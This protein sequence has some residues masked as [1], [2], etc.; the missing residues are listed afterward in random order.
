M[1]YRIGRH[2]TFLDEMIRDLSD[3][4]LPAL[5]GFRTSVPSD[6]AM[7][8][9]DAGATLLDILTFYEERIANEGY[10]RTATERRSLLELARLVGYRPRPGLSASVHLAFTVQN[11]YRLTIPRGTKAQS[12]PGQDELPQMFETSDPIEA[13]AEWNQLSV[14][15]RRPQLGPVPDPDGGPGAA[16]LW[17]KGV[18]TGLRRNAP[19]L[20]EEPAR[21]RPRLFRV[22]EVVVDDVAKRTRVALRPWLTLGIGR[23]TQSIAASYGT[24]GAGFNT[25]VVGPKVLATLE[26]IAEVASRKTD[27]EVL[28]RLTTTTMPKLR[29]LVA[30]LT[31]T[32][33]NLRPWLTSVIAAFD[34]AIELELDAIATP[35]TRPVARTAYTFGSATRSL[36]GG[37]G[38]LMARRASAVPTLASELGSRAGGTLG[39]VTALQPALKDVLPTV[40]ANARIAPMPAL[41]AYALRVRAGVFGNNA[42]TRLDGYRENGTPIVHEWDATDMF[43]AED[44]GEVHLDAS[45]EAVSPGSWVV[46]DTADVPPVFQDDAALHAAGHAAMRVEVAHYP[47]LFARAQ[48]VRSGGSRAAYG[49][50][51]PSTSVRIAD[52]SGEPTWITFTD[53]TTAPTPE[54]I[55]SA[56]ATRPT[57]DPF[58]VIRRT[59]VLAGAEALELDDAPIDDPLCDGT[60]TAAIELGDLHAGLEPG[61]WVIVS[62]ERTDVAGTSGVI[63]S[64]LRRIADVRHDAARDDTD[65]VLPGETMH[66]YVSLDRPLDYCYRRDTVTVWGN[67]ADAT[68]G[69]TQRETLGGGDGSQPFQQFT[70]RVGPLTHVASTDADGARSTLEERVN[71]VR[72]HERRSLAGAPPDAHD[73]VTSVT[74]DARTTITHGDGVRAARL[75]TGR[76]NVRAVYRVGIGRAANVGG[77]RISILASRP[78]GLSEVINPLPSSGGADP[79][80]AEQLRRNVPLGLQALDRLVSLRDYGDFARA[81]AG[82]GKA[83]VTQ[84]SHGGRETVHVTIAGADDIPILP[85]SDLFMNL[86]ASFIRLGDIRQPVTL[87]VRELVLLVIAARIRVADDYSWELV[88]PRVRAALLARFGFDRRELGQ[89]VHSSEVIATIAAVPGVEY[90][91]LD[92]FGGIP[93]VVAG[94]TAAAPDRHAI[95]PDEIA[96][97]VAARVA[98]VLPAGDAC[99]WSPP[100][101]PVRVRLAGH[102][103]N[104]MLAPA[105]LAILS[106]AVPSTLVLREIP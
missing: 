4:E 2:A 43:A 36:A 88:E 34:D 61:R 96:A 90:V 81:F 66:T 52:L 15:R 95:T 45:Y 21:A 69:E 32:A 51:G 79:D 18:S 84:L 23:I 31:A 8:M 27:A 103:E 16:V 82:V 93:A 59:S 63:A 104:G 94:G 25:G 65:T 14:R 100:F 62:G 48:S 53:D 101:C 98:G 47:L 57:R 83:S 26:E 77:G 1:R 9:L 55:A 78:L 44:P 86:Q 105:Q 56:T 73:Y 22:E 35:A 13:R 33:K 75:P 17:L 87:G 92:T 37:N 5:G 38:S 67:V 89:S 60:G 30:G 41:R 46:V 40:V 20:V 10:L 74:D 64:E 11:G 42:P 72:W 12:V 54:L 19:L 24:L 49:L 99:G 58:D 68:H 106:P 80:S 85:S 6:P 29:E 97:L 76:D 71:E 70:L 91:D 39:I 50:K 28:K 102:D 7:A 3:R